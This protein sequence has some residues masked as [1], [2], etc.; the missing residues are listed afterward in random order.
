MLSV[1]TDDLWRDYLVFRYLRWEKLQEHLYIQM[2]ALTLQFCNVRAYHS[3]RTHGSEFPQP[4]SFPPAAHG[5]KQTILFV[6]VNDN[7]ERSNP[8]FSS[9]LPL[10]ANLLVHMFDSLPPCEAISHKFLAL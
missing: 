5:P 8:C 3:V 9:V 7:S 1:Y 6:R 2:Q 4:R 10:F